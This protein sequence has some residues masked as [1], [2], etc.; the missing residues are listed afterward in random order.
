M[1]T[2]NSNQTAQILGNNESSEPYTSNIHNPRGLPG[3]F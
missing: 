3:E 1:F 2:S